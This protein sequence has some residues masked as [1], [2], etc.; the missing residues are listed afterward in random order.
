MSKYVVGID[1][2]DGSPYYGGSDQQYMDTVAAKLRE[3]G[4]TVDT[5]QV[6][7]NQETYLKGHGADYAVFLCNGV[8]P[9]TMWS[10]VSAI[11]AGSLPFTIFALEGWYHNPNEPGGTLESIDTVRNHPFEVPHDGNKSDQGAMNASSNATTT[12]EFVDENCYYS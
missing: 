12:G 7:P 10:F 8:D 11:K 6:G 5:T 2:G 9:W 3:C 1:K 4:N